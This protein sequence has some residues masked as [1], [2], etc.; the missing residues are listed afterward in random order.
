MEK[1]TKRF[2]YVSFRVFPLFF[3]L[4]TVA[5]IFHEYGHLLTANLLG[6]DGRIESFSYMVA[7]CSDD[8]RYVPIQFMGGIFASFMLSITFLIAFKT[9]YAK[10]ILFFAWVQFSYG[11]IEGIV[12]QLYLTITV[13]NNVLFGI[14]LGALFLFTDFKNAYEEL[15]S[16]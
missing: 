6:C 2:L 7:V 1:E 3:F 12:G 13:A 15:E 9:P 8:M 10:Y 11:I 4:G 16:P 5:V 14:G